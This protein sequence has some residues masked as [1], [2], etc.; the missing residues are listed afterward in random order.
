MG[1]IVDQK[2]VVE[3]QQDWKLNIGFWQEIVFL[4][5]KEFAAEIALNHFSKE[6]T[7]A[8]FSFQATK[9]KVIEGIRGSQNS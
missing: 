1:I 9:M 4:P 5:S 3:L 6:Y 2:N 7:K 8:F